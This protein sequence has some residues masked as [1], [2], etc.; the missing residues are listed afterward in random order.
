MTVCIRRGTTFHFPQ[1]SSE[2]LSDCL[3]TSY[4]LLIQNLRPS[5]VVKVSVNTSVIQCASSVLVV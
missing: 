5:K 1:G 3:T 4:A 2:G